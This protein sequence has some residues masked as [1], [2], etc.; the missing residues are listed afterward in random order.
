M[1]KWLKLNKNLS[2][3]CKIKA[4]LARILSKGRVSCG[5]I[6]MLLIFQYVISYIN[7]VATVVIADYGK[8]L[9]CFIF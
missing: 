7:G 6:M 1:G 5:M 4:F 8:T 9:F 3:D 2:N